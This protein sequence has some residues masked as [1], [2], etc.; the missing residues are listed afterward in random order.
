MTNGTL[1]LAGRHQLARREHPPTKRILVDR[2]SENGLVNALQLKQR[3]LLGKEF[4]THRGVVDFAPQT[5]DAH[6]DNS[7]MVEGESK[8]SVV[9]VEHLDIIDDRRV[10]YPF[11]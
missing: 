4:I 11:L 10:G 6:A 5:L 2:A 3:E 1:A 7:A 9:G 8:G